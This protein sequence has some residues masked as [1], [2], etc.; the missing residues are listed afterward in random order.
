MIS[1]RRL[2]LLVP[3]TLIATLVFP[4]TAMAADAPTR[5]AASTIAAALNRISTPTT[6]AADFTARATGTA[7]II[8]GVT[9]TPLPFFRNIVFFDVVTP[10]GRLCVAV[11]PT[12]ATKP[13]YSVMNADC[14]T[15]ANIVGPDLDRALLAVAK[16]EIRLGLNISA[17]SLFGLRSAKFTP[18]IIRNYAASLDPT[19]YTVVDSPAGVQISITDRPS[20]KFTVTADARGRY[21]I[22]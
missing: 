4:T 13:R 17:R 22:A 2:W 14:Q 6:T 5:K 20:V 12:S 16:T 7:Q 3:F 21:R 9:V 11:K 10:G 18:Q 8:A 15:Y 1:T 19:K